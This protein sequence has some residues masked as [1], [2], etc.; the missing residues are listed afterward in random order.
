MS[1]RKRSFE[2]DTV[3]SIHKKKRILIKN[4]YKR[5]AYSVDEKLYTQEE[6]NALLTRQ[7]QSFRAILEE[8][9]KEQFNMFNQLYIDNIF[10]DYNRADTSYIN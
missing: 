1:C 6:V 4:V 10:K 9:L 3:D 5:D 8:K 7:E 2:E